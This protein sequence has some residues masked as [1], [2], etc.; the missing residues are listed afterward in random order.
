MRK[1]FLGN[2]SLRKKRRFREASILLGL[3]LVFAIFHVWTRMEV[4]QTGYEIRR[5]MTQREELKGVSHSLRV[6]V[7]TLRSPV[8]LEEV[9]QRLGLKKPPEKQV[10]LISSLPITSPG[11]P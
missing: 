6:E 5:L 8:H 4:V 2:Q 10:T 3:T 1:R 11:M 9:A 7:A